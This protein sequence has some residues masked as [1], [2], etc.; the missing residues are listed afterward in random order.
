MSKTMNFGIIGRSEWLYDA[1]LRLVE[2]G[3]RPTF[4]VTAIEAPEYRR[5]AED[6]Q[7]LAHE[8]DIPF[9]RTAR[10]SSSEAQ[11]FLDAAEPTDCVISINYSSIIGDDVIG[12]YR[13]GVLNAHGGDLP[14]YR[15]NACQA[16]AIINGETEV[17][18]CI[19]RMVPGELDSG[20]ILA[21]RYLPTPLG[22][23]VGDIY[24]WFDDVVPQL[25]VE[26]VTALGED[27]N[28]VMAHQSTNAADAL[29]CYPRRPE[30]GRIDWTMSPEAVVRL[31]CASGS[32]F[33]GAFSWLGRTK[34]H[35]L[36]ACIHDDGEQ[37]C[38]V[39][40]QILHIDE[41]AGQIIVCAGIGKVCLSDFRFADQTPV[42]FADHFTSIRQRFSAI[43][44]D[45]DVS[46]HQR[47]CA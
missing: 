10:L 12:R 28:F 31:V 8:L 24:A 42:S 3:H 34:I 29:R 22:T 5:T 13:L 37:F 17:A 6:F 1:V 9:L 19:H 32:P 4:I 45:T 21:R 35:I 14:R 33:S 43:G 44:P 27:Q 46:G 2:C 7:A 25:C 47:T 18:M 11:E 20:D 26:A 39:P 15:G 36:D 40:G 23:K 38:A 41:K 16:W 30:D